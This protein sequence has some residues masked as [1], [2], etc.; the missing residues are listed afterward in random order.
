M[1]KIPE[2]RKEAILANMS[3]LDCKPVAVVAAEEGVS[4]ATLYK[5]HWRKQARREGRLLP[6]QN[7]SPEGWSARIRSNF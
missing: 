1:K 4:T 2:E 6:D 7:D 5:C 3:G